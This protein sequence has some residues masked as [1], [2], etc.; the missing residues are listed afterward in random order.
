[1]PTRASI[2]AFLAGHRIAV[3]GVSRDP[4]HFA[5]AVYRELRDHGYEVI[6][7]NPH[8]DTVEGDACVRSVAEL[9]D[10]DGVLVMVPAPAAAEV[11]EACADRG[12]PRVWLHKGGGPGAVSEDAVRVA[13]ER[14]LEVVDG[15][16][17]LMF[18]EPTGWIHRLHRAISGRRVLTG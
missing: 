8:A 4:K 13:R 18:L 2:D 11:V 15:A 6:G 14:G 1:M 17:P 7:V 12:L 5:N 10:V 3:V 9:P 16:C